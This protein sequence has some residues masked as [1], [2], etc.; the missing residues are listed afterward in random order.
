MAKA[1]TWPPRR[2]SRLAQPSTAKSRATAPKVQGSSSHH[3][4]L[5]FCEGLIRHRPPRTPPSNSPRPSLLRGQF[6]I[7]I[8]SNQ[9]IEVESMSSRCQIDVKS[10]REERTARRIRGWGPGG[11]CLISP[12]QLL[13]CFSLFLFCRPEQPSNEKSKALT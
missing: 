7:E 13:F 12:S 8:G 9:E 2:C 1:I 6:G 10:T 4:L 11:L 3:F 5:L